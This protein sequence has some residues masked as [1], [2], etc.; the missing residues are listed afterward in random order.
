MINFSLINLSLFDRCVANTK[1][2]H[3]Q[4]LGKDTDF[5]SRTFASVKLDCKNIAI[6]FLYC[7]NLV[8]CEL[9]RYQNKLAQQF[10]YGLYKLQAAFHKIF[11]TRG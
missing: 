10:T 5:Q 1:H 6:V 11:T 2:A 4:A 3:M 8:L 9:R 7:E